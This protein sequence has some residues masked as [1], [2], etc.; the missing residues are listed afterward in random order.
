MS[1]DGTLTGNVPPVII[2]TFGRFDLVIQGTPLRFTRR[3]PIRTLQFLGALIA[4]GGRGVSHGALADALW[5]DAE[6][7]DA[8]RC[9]TMTLYRLRTL[10]KLPRAVTLSAG[11]VSLD[12]ALCHVDVWAFERALRQARDPEA[13]EAA[14]SL[15]HGPFLGDD[16]Q[17][18]AIGMRLRLQQLATRARLEIER[19][20]Q[21]GLASLPRAWR[22]LSV[23]ASTAS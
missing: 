23:G 5:P 11:R 16:S 9:F 19:H 22:E 6:G 10:L 13:L 12:P 14:L 1:T 15:Y 2:H 18:W 7:D 21:N 20:S 3:A 17:P 4:H 8:F